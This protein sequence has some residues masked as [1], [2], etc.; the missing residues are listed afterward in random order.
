MSARKILVE[1][2]SNCEAYSLRFVRT[3]KGEAYAMKVDYAG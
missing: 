3:S 1:K 2:R